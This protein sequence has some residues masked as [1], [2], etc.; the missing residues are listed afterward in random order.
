MGQAVPAGFH[1][2][3]EET[4]QRVVHALPSAFPFSPSV[5]MATLFLIVD[6]QI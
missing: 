2:V 4:P 3:V 5:D 6:A 1:T